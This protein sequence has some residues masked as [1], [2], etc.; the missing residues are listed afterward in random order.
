MQRR[1][2]I[3]SFIFYLSFFCLISQNQKLDSL[4]NVLTTYTESD[5]TKA[6][7]VHSIAQSY[8]KAGLYHEA[9][10]Y[11]NQVLE[12]SQKLEFQIGIYKAYLQKGL[13]NAGLGNLKLA[14]NNFSSA[15]KTCQFVRDTLGI[16]KSYVYI[17]NLYVGEGEN[18]FAK[19]NYLLALK[20]F[21]AIKDY[22]NQGIVYNNLGAVYDNLA[23]TNLA[24]ESYYSAI[25]IYKAINDE[26]N[27]AKTYNNIAELYNTQG[28][29]DKALDN[30]KTALIY[31]KQYDDKSTT[32]I[33]YIN[34]ADVYFRLKNFE[35]SKKMALTGLSLNLELQDRSN[36][37]NVYL[38]LAQSDSA[39]GNWKSAYAYHQHYLNY[40]FEL[41]KDNKSIE[42]K[43]LGIKY[44]TEKK[45]QQLLLLKKEQAISSSQSKLQ[46]FFLWLISV[47]TLGIAFIAFLVWRS[48]NQS[49]KVNTIIEEQRIAV[50]SAK[51]LLESKN[52]DFVDS[53]EYAKIIQTS[54][55]SHQSE[56]KA[57]WSESFILY[58]PKDILSGDFYFLHKNSEKQYYLAAADC[59]GHGVPGAFMSIVG[60]EK[61]KEATSL[62]ESPSAILK[63]LNNS[64]KTILFQ[65]E[66]KDIAYDGLDIA[67]CLIDL[68]TLQV[69]FAGAN[70]PMWIISKGANE[71]IEI[72]GT[73]NS[74]G[75]FA[76]DNH[77]YK[78]HNIQLSKGDCIYLFSDGYSDTFKKNQVRGK[79][80]NK[81]FRQL[82]MSIQHLSMPEQGKYLDTYIEDWKAGAEQTDDILVLGIRV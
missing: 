67:L 39:L 24:I 14:L 52:R 44:E 36:L 9:L 57:I 20:Y 71:I 34:L 35:Q 23:I 53:I 40:N 31:A 42:I 62:Y 54:L 64:I 22:T 60:S 70:R 74:I 73:K 7:L 3:T 82:L 28:K 43:E 16:A 2:Y 15:L 56:L 75:G 50:E 55:L 80:T 12:L 46:K 18:T 59:T 76:P 8:N 78:E 30:F 38:I 19:D 81:R 69:K 47:I 25:F 26:H 68:E 61:L 1:I 45:E 65:S 27:I 41:L 10:N 17:G 37:M 29:Y 32:A 51:K 4:L 6:N 13:A 33:I 66:N 58:K 5:S 72:N 49:K 21:K 77:Q 48:L 63:D 79:F 11:S